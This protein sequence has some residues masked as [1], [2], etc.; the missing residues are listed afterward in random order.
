MVKNAKEVTWYI[1]RLRS[2]PAQYLGTVEA[3][4]QATA[5]KRAIEKFKVPES[6]QWRLFA[7]QEL[8]PRRAL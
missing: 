4:D 2:M 3:S 7:E 8:G 1:Y 5:M 6:D